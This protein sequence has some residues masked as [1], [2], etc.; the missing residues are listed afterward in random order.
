M[1]H[2]A[3]DADGGD[4]A[5]SLDQHQFQ[6]SIHGGDYVNPTDPLFG[7]N[8]AIGTGQNPNDSSPYE[9]NTD[10]MARGGSGDGEPIP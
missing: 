8:T 6:T 7:E 1:I 2:V 4:G 3:P 10:A 5:V 9:H